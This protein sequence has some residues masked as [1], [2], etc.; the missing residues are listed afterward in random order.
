MTRLW[1]PAPASRLKEQRFKRGVIQVVQVKAYCGRR[2]RNEEVFSWTRVKPT[3][4]DWP[5]QEKV[6]GDDQAIVHQ[7]FGGGSRC[8]CCCCRRLQQTEQ[9]RCRSQP[10]AVPEAG[11]AQHLHSQTQPHE[12]RQRPQDKDEFQRRP[13]PTT[14]KDSNHSARTGK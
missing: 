3:A 8:C 11:P 7:T 6:S 2:R 12:I 5:V 1:K 9:W 4:Q 14:A 10:V 13:D